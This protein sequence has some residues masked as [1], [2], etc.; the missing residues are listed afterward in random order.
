MLRE[1]R[2]VEVGDGM[3]RVKGFLLHMDGHWTVSVTAVVDGIAATADDV[4]DL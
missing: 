2:S 3:Y 1:P 4:L